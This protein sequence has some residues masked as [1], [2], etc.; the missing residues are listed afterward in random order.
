MTKIDF[1]NYMNQ[2]NMKPIQVMNEKG[3]IVNQ[4][5]FPDLTDDQLVDLFKKMLWERILNERSTK[6]NRQ[7]R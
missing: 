7:G 2:P 5:L 1:N 4:D 6:L 3:E